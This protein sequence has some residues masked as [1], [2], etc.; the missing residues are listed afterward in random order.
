V[1]STKRLQRALHRVNLLKE[2]VREFYSN[3]KI[4]NDLIE[5]RNLLLVAEL[6]IHS[7]LSRKES[8]G[9]HYTRDYP[10]ASPGVPQNTILTS[11]QFEASGWHA[12][13]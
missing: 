11:P 10:Q 8:R 6:T 4:T 2:E 9:L 1:R 5:L 13:A 3:F 7:A 12:S